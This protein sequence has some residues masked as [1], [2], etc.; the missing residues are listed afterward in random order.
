MDETWPTNDRP[1]TTSGATSTDPAATVTPFP[2]AQNQL[3]S[4]QAGLKEAGIAQFLYYPPSPPPL[5]PPHYRA[6]SAGCPRHGVQ[7]HGHSDSALANKDC[8]GGCTD[9]QFRII[10][11]NEP[12]NKAWTQL[13]PQ[14]EVF[15][16]RFFGDKLLAVGSAEG[17]HE[18]NGLL[19]SLSNAEFQDPTTAP[20]H[21]LQAITSNM[22]RARAHTRATNFIHDILSIQLA[23]LVSS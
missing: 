17:Q 1:S 7:A 4:N 22:K 15:L 11:S 2:N 8:E 6:D 18:L 14:A 23:A 13:T 12:P 10:G 21:K 19:T 3:P 16:A 9:S 5:P 20:A